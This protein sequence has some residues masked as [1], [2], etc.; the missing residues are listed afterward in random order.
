[1]K[2]RT[3]QHNALADLASLQ[4]LSEGARSNYISA[5]AQKAM[6]Q[7]LDMA[8]A[9][10]EEEK[11]RQAAIVE[12]LFASDFWPVRVKRE[13]GQGDENSLLELDSKIDE[14]KGQVMAL[15][16]DVLKNDRVL[17][18]VVEW[19]GSRVIPN[20]VVDIVDPM[21]TDRGLKRR[22]LDSDA[23]VDQSSKYEL[24]STSSSMTLVPTPAP[25]L[26]PTPT[27][28]SG[29]KTEEDDKDDVSTVM[30]RIVTVSNRLRHLEEAVHSA[31]DESDN[32]IKEYVDAEMEEV[33]MKFANKKGEHYTKRM[34]ELKEDIDSC[35]KDIKDLSDELA[36]QIQGNVKR[37]LEVAQLREE[38]HE[39]RATILQVRL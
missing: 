1:M 8:K 18:E 39:R 11:K 31:A 16:D 34:L 29:L 37:N 17:R 35:G 14:M 25:E 22:R 30:R 15:A 7:A 6:A 36:D 3:A 13:G 28:A 10:V 9:K 21:E 19:I 4:K 20:T 26:P 23:F 5:E 32:R 2:A 33:K 12:K 27:T 38:V 24:T